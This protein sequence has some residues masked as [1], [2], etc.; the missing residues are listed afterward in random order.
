MTRESR[1]AK[2]RQ[3]IID[4]NIAG[5]SDAEIGRRIGKNRSTV[6]RWRKGETSP[7]KYGG[8]GLSRLWNREEAAGRLKIGAGGTVNLTDFFRKVWVKDGEVV[9]PLNLSPVPSYSFPSNAAVSIIAKFSDWLLITGENWPDKT[10]VANVSIGSN[11]VSEITSALYDA[12]ERQKNYPLIFARISFVLMR[13]G[14]ND[15]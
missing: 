5:L 4:L 2:A 12:M 14:A 8:G 13:R 11:G 7:Q 15:A 10:I 9:E 6:G 1:G 3:Q